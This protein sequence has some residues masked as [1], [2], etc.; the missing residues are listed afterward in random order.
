MEFF[1]YP[2][3]K[4]HAGQHRHFVSRII[5]KDNQAAIDSGESS[6]LIETASLLK[7][8]LFTHVAIQDKSLLWFFKKQRDP[9]LKYSKELV[10][11][12]KEGSR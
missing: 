7:N 4:A 8:W 6:K 9:L 12:Y 11:K 1:D 3:L 5:S 2:G 10:K